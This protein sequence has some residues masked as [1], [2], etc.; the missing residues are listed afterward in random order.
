MIIEKDLFLYMFDI[1]EYY[2]YSDFMIKKVFKIIRNIITTKNEDIQEML[3][4]MLEETD[5]IPFL[6]RNG[7]T[8]MLSE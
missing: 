6:L 3:R 7:P 8:V 1:V 2:K 4:Y 5:M